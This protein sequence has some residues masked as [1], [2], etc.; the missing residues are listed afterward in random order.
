[1]PKDYNPDEPFE[2]LG[3]LGWLKVVFR[4]RAQTLRQC[5]TMTKMLFDKANEAR[6]EADQATAALGRL[7]PLVVLQHRALELALPIL[8]SEL[9]LGME[10]WITAENEVK[11]A[12]DL[13]KEKM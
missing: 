9:V 1:M 11:Y 6:A 5:D 13:A 3:I 12:I 7:S 8:K 10:Q 2:G 4:T